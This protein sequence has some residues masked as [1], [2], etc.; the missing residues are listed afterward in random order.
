MVGWLALAACAVPSPEACT[1]APLSSGEVFAGPLRCD[2]WR[3]PGGDGRVGDHVLRNSKLTAVVRH[4]ADGLTVPGGRGGTLVDLAAW[5]G[6]RWVDGVLEVVPPAGGWPDHASLEAGVDGDVGWVAWPDGRRWTLA[7]DDLALGL[8]DSSS[9]WALPGTGGLGL[10]L[11]E[12]MAWAAAEATVDGWERRLGLPWLAA[13]SPAEVT[14]WLWPDGVVLEGL[15]AG[16]AVEVAAPDGTLELPPSFDLLVPAG[17]RVRCVTEGGLAGPWT[18]A[19][20]GLRLEPEGPA[21][22]V[23]AADVEGA[24]LAAWVQTSAGRVVLPPEGAWVPA[25]D[26]SV[27]RS[28]GWA[29]W[30][31][32]AGAGGVTVAVLERS[33]PEGWLAQDLRREA[34]PSPSEP[35]DPATVLAEAA[36]DGFSCAVLGTLAEVAPVVDEGWPGA[37]VRVRGGAWTLAAQGLVRSWPWA[38]AAGVALH[39]A[40]DGEGLDPWDGLWAVEEGGLRRTVADVTWLALAGAPADWDPAPTALE[41]ADGEDVPAVLEAWS[42]GARSPAVGPVTWTPGPAGLPSSAGCDRGLVVGPV[43]AGSGPLPVIELARSRVG[44]QGPEHTLDLALYAGEGVERLALWVDGQVIQVWEAPSSG[45]TATVEL[46]GVR[47]VAALL[48]E[49]EEWAVAGPLVLGP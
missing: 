29:P 28:H 40:V 37:V 7:A 49:G 13:G 16:D 26:V 3:V 43:T 24:P 15:C 18:D 27:E 25:G 41:L 34:W 6:Q 33:V 39:G 12:G 21:A 31:G 36:A 30:Q 38:P 17:S 1:A 47:R 19:G 20:P 14:A 9:W 23:R 8:P 22:F 11:R 4:P 2:A 32:V 10:V 35:R 46:L 45:W 44:W 48:A 5:D 42:A